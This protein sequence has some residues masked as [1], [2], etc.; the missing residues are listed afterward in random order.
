[1]RMTT[2]IHT[3]IQTAGLVLLSQYPMRIAAALQVT[4]VN[5][6]E[7]EEPNRDKP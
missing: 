2:T 5:K 3:E 1:M 4:G 7:K 6:T